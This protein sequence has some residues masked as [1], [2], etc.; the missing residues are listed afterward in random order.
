MM[1]GIC[2]LLIREDYFSEIRFDKIQ[3]S[4]SMCNY[5]GVESRWSA[6]DHYYNA[7]II[8]QKYNAYFGNNIDFVYISRSHVNAITEIP[9]R[10]N[11]RLKKSSFSAAIRI[12]D[13]E[14][15]L[16]IYSHFIIAFTYIYLYLSVYRTFRPFIVNR[17]FKSN[18]IQ[19]TAILE[20]SKR[21]DNIIEV[22]LLLGLI[23]DVR[24]MLFYAEFCI[25]NY[26]SNYV[27]LIL[28]SQNNRFIMLMLYYIIIIYYICPEVHPE[29]DLCSYKKKENNYER[30]S[31]LFNRSRCCLH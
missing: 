24:F 21:H 10:I 14:L 27:I 28:I 17:S 23:A 11:N 16:Y 29:W 12:T 4:D 13:W 8:T 19:I 3:N 20:W 7:Q 2:T 31:G 1:Y 18:I 5:P 22:R 15:I 30:L 9:C 26:K 25:C 6:P